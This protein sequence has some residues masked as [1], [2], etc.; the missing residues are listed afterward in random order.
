LL[1]PLEG[2]RG[3]GARQG[4]HRGRQWLIAGERLAGGP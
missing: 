2:G 4:L 3:G 1:T